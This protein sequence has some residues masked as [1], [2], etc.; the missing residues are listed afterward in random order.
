MNLNVL[1]ILKLQSSLGGG[2]EID[3]LGNVKVKGSVEAQKYFVNTEDSDSA[4]AGK[5]NLTSGQT[6]IVIESTSATSSSQIFATPE[7][8]VAVGTKYIEPGKFE[9]RI[10]S[11]EASNLPISWWIIN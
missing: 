11:P 1:G 5:A 6:V 7:R 2:V 3:Q 10:Q 8:P 9:I 4:S